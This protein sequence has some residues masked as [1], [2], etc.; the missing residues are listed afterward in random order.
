M[1]IVIMKVVCVFLVQAF[2]ASNLLKI[3]TQKH[4][5]VRKGP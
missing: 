3:Y 5:E 1:G 4:S 2:G